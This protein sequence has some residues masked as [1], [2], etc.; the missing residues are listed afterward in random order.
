MQDALDRKIITALQ[1]NA[2]QSTAQLAAQ[3]NVART[4]IHSR[5]TRMENRGVI[6]GYTVRLGVDEDRPQV[7]ITILVA[8][9]QPETQSVLKRLELYPEIKLCLSVNG[10]FD[11][12]IS[13]EAPRIEDLD[14]LVDEMAEIPGV[15]RT[16]T[17][18]V[19]GRKID[20]T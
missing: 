1:T 19:F 11:L 6:K 12:L 20:R 13:A 14:I 15:I 3:L 17:L 4:T 9:Q 7:Q 8:V 18:V 5:I 16:N 2:R 10:E